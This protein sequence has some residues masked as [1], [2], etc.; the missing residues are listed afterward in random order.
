MRLAVAKTET[1]M[2]D[3]SPYLTSPGAMLGTVAYMSPAQIAHR[4]RSAWPTATS[5][6]AAAHPLLIEIAF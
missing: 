3:D 6:H 2:G 1:L 4:S 5:A